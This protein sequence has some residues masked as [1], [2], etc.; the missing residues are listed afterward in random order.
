MAMPNYAMSC[1]KLPINLCKEIEREIINYW[2]KGHKEHKGI[3]WVGWQRLFMMKE[4]RGIG[5]RDLM[6]FNLA[7]LGKI[8]WWIIK[9]PE[10]LLVTTFRD[11][12]FRSSDFMSVAGSR[13]TSGGWKGILQGRKILE[14]GMRWRIGNKHQ[15]RICLDNWVPKPLTF[16]IYSRHPNM[17][18]L[19]QGLIDDQTKM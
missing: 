14:V 3:H 11:K 6:C 12:Y 17:S 5:F 10:S 19:V 2:C 15:V 8:G 7:M 1:F 16:K 13:G 4:A 9:H 18:I